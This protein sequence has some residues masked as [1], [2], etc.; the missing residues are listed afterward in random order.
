M[1]KSL[2]AAAVIVLPLAAQAGPLSPPS[3]ALCATGEQMTKLMEINGDAALLF[4][5]QVDAGFIIVYAATDGHFA[6][7]TYDPETDV[8]CIAAQGNG[9]SMGNDWLDFIRTHE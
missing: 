2:I 7:T 9:G 5:G 4:A 3:K 1:L 6:L 8:E